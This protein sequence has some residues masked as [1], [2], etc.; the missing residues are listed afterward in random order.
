MTFGNLTGLTNY[1][2]RVFP[3]LYGISLIS[4]IRNYSTGIFV[5]FGK[6]GLV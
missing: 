3:I 1:I 2:N 6:K 4:R 5:F